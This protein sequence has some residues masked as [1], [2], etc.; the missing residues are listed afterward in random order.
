[1][2]RVPVLSVIG[3]LL[4]AVGVFAQ[5]NPSAGGWRTLS[6]P[7]IQDT[8]TTM[9]ALPFR[10]FCERVGPGLGAVMP[11]YKS[12]GPPR[13]AIRSSSPLLLHRVP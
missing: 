10:A 6:T 1:M 5:E 9:G 11:P 4:V 2:R 12:A 8:L 13:A 3:V 7:T